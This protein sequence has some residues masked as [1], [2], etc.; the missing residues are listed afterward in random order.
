MIRPASTHLISGPPSC[1]VRARAGLLVRLMFAGLAFA[2]P[3]ATPSQGTADHQ[4]LPA[5]VDEDQP[6]VDR[7]VVRELA[8]EEYAANDPRDD[9][10]LR[11]RP[12]RGPRD[13]GPEGDHPRA[14]HRPPHEFDGPPR[15]GW[16]GD[17]DRGGLREFGRGDGP[18]PRGP[19]GPLPPFRHDGF[20][21][22][23]PRFAHHH[24]GPHPGVD[25]WRHGPRHPEHP[26]DEML[27]MLHELR[28]E[29]VIL[30]HEIERL[31]AE[32]RPGPREDPRGGAPEEGRRGFRGPPPG[33]E[34]RDG[35]RD[36]RGDERDGGRRHGDRPSDA[37]PREERPPRTGA[38]ED[39]APREEVG[40]RV[41]IGPSAETDPA[42]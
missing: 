20:R 15:R 16:R 23:P 28:H 12:E 24:G 29:V 14:R 19:H 22:G 41:E 9:E 18:G 40:Q 36:G 2:A 25:G 4:D 13:F 10:G 31:R 8:G 34:P 3:L 33:R 38:A 30:R 21:G 11:G 37:P 27:R 26:D 32:V 5:V 42:Q 35:F 17:D 1:V 6:A 39:I 7:D